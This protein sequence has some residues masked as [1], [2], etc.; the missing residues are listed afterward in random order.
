[1][2]IENRSASAE[3]TWLG[4]S[5]EASKID[6]ITAA[7]NAWRARD[8]TTGGYSHTSSARANAAAPP[9]DPSAGKRVGSELDFDRLRAWTLAAFIVIERAC[10]SGGPQAAALPAGIS[11]VD[12]SVHVL[13]KHAHRIG[14]AQR[15]ESAVHQG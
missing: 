2:T 15:D 11:I 3:E 8:R 5:S 4:E 10:A 7:A 6:P 9:I 12:T 14:H 1:M 13:R